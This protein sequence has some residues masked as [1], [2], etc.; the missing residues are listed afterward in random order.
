MRIAAQASRPADIDPRADLQ[1]LEAVT[2]EQV[3]ETLLKLCTDTLPRVFGVDPVRDTQVLTPM[4]KGVAGVAN[5]NA[6]LQRALNPEGPGLTQ[7]GVVYRPGDKLIQLRNNYEKSVFNGDLGTVTR[8]DAES[9]T[10]TAD[11][12][13]ETH[14]FERTELNDLAL[15]YAVTIHKSQGSEYPV[16][17]L[18]LLKQHFVM[19]R[20]NLVYTGITRGRKKVF[21]I[22]NPGAYAMALRNNETGARHTCLQDL[23]RSRAAD[24]TSGR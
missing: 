11:F 10:L 6:S 12:D 3:V 15:A 21:L 14:V 5:L 7:G 19:L 13:D 18:L 24:P 2:P 16:V 4:H 17:V 23:I 1:F 9:G 22:G 20:R 8:V